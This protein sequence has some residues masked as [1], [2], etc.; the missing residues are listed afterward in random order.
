MLTQSLYNGLK[1]GI[2]AIPRRHNHCEFTYFRDAVS[3]NRVTTVSGSSVACAYKLA[4]NLK[5]SL[6]FFLLETFL[7][8]MTQKICHTAAITLLSNY[9]DVPWQLTCKTVGAKKLSTVDAST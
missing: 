7:Q 3:L 9:F 1:V 4:E 8:Q 6:F 5:L 2:C